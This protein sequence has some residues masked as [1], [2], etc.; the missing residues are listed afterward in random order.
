MRTGRFLVLGSPQ[1]EGNA[2]AGRWLGVLQE[3]THQG[4]T[5]LGRRPD[6][7]PRPRW[8]GEWGLVVQRFHHG[9]RLA[10]DEGQGMRLSPTIVH[11]RVVVG[12]G[13]DT[14]ATPWPHRQAG[15]D[16][17]AGGAIGRAVPPAPS[18]EAKQK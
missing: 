15:V 12:K 9:L 18:M 2:P 1:G 4:K 10:S 17:Q 8:L 7:A 16:E 11:H 6:K 5:R 13:Q 14:P 3:V